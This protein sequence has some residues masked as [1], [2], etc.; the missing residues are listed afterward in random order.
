MANLHPEVLTPKSCKLSSS[1]VEDISDWIKLNYDI[2]M[3]MWKTY[4][5]G[6]GSLAKLI[7]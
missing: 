1:N 5:T 7:L 2:L 6:T 4:E 3:K